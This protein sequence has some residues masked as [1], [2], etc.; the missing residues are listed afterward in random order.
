[1]LWRAE[2]DDDWSNRRVHTFA[3]A[4]LWKNVVFCNVVVNAVRLIY[5][6]YVSVSS[7]LYTKWAWSL[8]R[9]YS[10][11]ELCQFTYVHDPEAAKFNQF[12]LVHTYICG[13][14]FVKIRSV[15]FM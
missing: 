9:R 14:I 3:K 2:D 12:F 11:V 4:K 15:A 6:P 13:E 7:P 1:M 10:T 8:N 5:Y